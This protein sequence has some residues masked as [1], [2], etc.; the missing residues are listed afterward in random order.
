MTLKINIFLL[1][2]NNHQSVL[3]SNSN[4]YQCNCILMLFFSFMKV[5]LRMFIEGPFKVDGLCKQVDSSDLI[6]RCDG[7]SQITVN[8]K[9]KKNI[10]KLA[11]ACR[12]V[13]RMVVV[14]GGELGSSASTTSSTTAWPASN[15]ESSSGSCCQR[16]QDSHLVDTEVRA[17]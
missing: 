11:G 12:P 10:N 6:T 15:Q 3:Y 2:L 4:K 13:W 1:R 17:Q 14:P 7:E 8:V 16:S 9:Q 5:I